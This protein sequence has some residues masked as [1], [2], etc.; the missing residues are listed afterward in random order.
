MAFPRFLPLCHS[1]Q[2]QSLVKG[3]ADTTLK[4]ISNLT[5]PDQEPSLVA[6]DQR[7]P[8]VM[9]LPIHVL[10]FPAFNHANLNPYC[11]QLYH[12]LARLGVKIEEF[13]FLKPFQS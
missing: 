11:S 3:K 5:L 6:T 8:R 7:G 9:N 10:A 4:E 12:E 2:F 1:F 13:S